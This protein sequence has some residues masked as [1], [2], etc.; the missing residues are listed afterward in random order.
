VSSASR[1]DFWAA[2]APQLR[3]KWKEERQPSLATSHGTTSAK[4]SS[5]PQ[6]R[7]WPWFWRGSLCCPSAWPPRLEQWERRSRRSWPRRRPLSLPSRDMAELS[8]SQGAAALEAQQHR[9]CRPWL[10]RQP[11][12]TQPVEWRLEC[13]SGMATTFGTRSRARC[14]LFLCSR[15]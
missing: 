13:G 7:V 5:P 3:G 14:V 1:R 2:D 15:F 11:S 8:S 10:Q 12:R 9:S 4:S 6:P